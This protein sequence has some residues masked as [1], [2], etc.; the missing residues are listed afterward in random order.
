MPYVNTISDYPFKNVIENLTAEVT[1]SYYEM[2]ISTIFNRI[3]WNEIVWYNPLTYPAKYRREQISDIINSYYNIVKNEAQYPIYNAGLVNKGDRDQWTL[4]FRVEK[5]SSQNNELVRK[6]L[7][8]L[9]YATK[10]GTIKTSK[11]LDPRTA[12]QGEKNRETPG[13]VDSYKNSPIYKAGEIFSS[14]L[15]FVL[16]NIIPIAVIGG[17]L[18][19]AKKTGLLD[20]GFNSVKS[21]VSGKKST[22]NDNL[23]GSEWEKPTKTDYFYLWTT[24]NDVGI[25][26]DLDKIKDRYPNETVKVIYKSLH[27]ED[28]KKKEANFLKTDALFDKRTKK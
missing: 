27:Y 18:Y 7:D 26:K 2:A 23:F 1:Q 19:V 4:I 8:Q 5:D 16:T 10:D 17:G 22:L 9:Y 13:E 28:V 14:G 24:K 21:K 11:F 20:K 6:A 3:N 25:T 12:E 15:G